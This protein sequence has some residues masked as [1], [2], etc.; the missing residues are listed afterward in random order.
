VT[1]RF[2]AML[3]AAN[4]QAKAPSTFLHGTETVGMARTRVSDAAARSG[5]SKMDGSCDNERI[6]SHLTPD[7]RH[8]DDAD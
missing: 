1:A 7:P 3:T 2:A 5:R 8:A 6:N 4:Q